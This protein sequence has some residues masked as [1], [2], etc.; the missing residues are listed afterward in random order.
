MRRFARRRGSVA[1]PIRL[2]ELIDGTMVLMGDRFR[3]ANVP[4]DMPERSDL[5]VF[6]CRIRSEQVLV[7][8]LQNAL[9]AVT[10]HSDPHVAIIIEQDEEQVSLVVADNG[11]GIDPNWPTKFS[12]P[13]SPVSRRGLVWGLVSRAI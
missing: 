12:A 8:L 5:M 1:R 10:A 9:D 6:A 13:L 3:N 2:D 11:P 7:N 4:L